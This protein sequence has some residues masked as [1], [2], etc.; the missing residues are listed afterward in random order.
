MSGYLSNSTAR[1][2]AGLGFV[3]GI[4]GF[5]A[6]ALGQTA[7]IS[8]PPSRSL[9]DISAWLQRDT[10]ILPGQVVDI[11]PSA[12]TAVTSLT[13]MGETRGFLAS[14][15]S[16]ATDPSVLAREGIA[17]WTIPVEVD[18]DRR[19]VRLGTMTGYPGRDL[20]SD[21]HVVRQADSNWVVP[22]PNAPLGA[23][24]RALCDRDFRRPLSGRVQVATKT[25]KPARP[26]P[27]HAIEPPPVLRPALA[28]APV[29]IAQPAPGSKPGPVAAAGGAFA[30]QIGASPSLPDIQSLLARFNK[31]FAAELNGHTAGV[32]TVQ[33]DGK[34]VNRALISGFASSAEANTFC[35][36]LAAAGQAC[37]VR[38]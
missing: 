35:K 10:P 19:V 11:S 31:K 18:C 34:T 16:E 23:V 38:R 6:P 15:S 5:A 37:F 26:A 25:P 17:A 28:P 1:R 7:S 24:V 30:V 36:T 14:I 33:V 13:P 9:G 12:V 21:A 4:A 8:Y 2:L 22:T 3:V 32:A 27:S 29:P 20:R